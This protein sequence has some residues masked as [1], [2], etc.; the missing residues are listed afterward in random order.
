VESGWQGGE[1]L[2]LLADA[3]IHSSSLISEMDFRSY[4]DIW[5]STFRWLHG[6]CTSIYD[7]SLKDDITVAA[8]V[9]KAGGKGIPQ[10]ALFYANLQLPIRPW[11][12]ENI[13]HRKDEHP[14]TADAGTVTFFA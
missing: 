8:D 3:D 4:I 6:Q 12:M 10:R 14:R 5:D 11:F 9:R 1:W 13:V 7:G 2:R